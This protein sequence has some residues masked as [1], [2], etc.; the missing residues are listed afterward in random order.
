MKVFKTIIICLFAM[1]GFS[2]SID[3]LFSKHKLV[4]GLTV[5]IKNDSSTFGGFPSNLVAIITFKSDSASVYYFAFAYQQSDSIN[6]SK[7]ELDYWMVSGC[8]I[9]PHKSFDKNFYSFI[10]GGYF[11][12]LQH[13]ACR[14]G[15]NEYCAELASRINQWRKKY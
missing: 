4:A 5:Q 9:V 8:N 14:T 6:F 13:C 7:A 11:F 12:L 15:E 10:Y 3:S 1:Q 2:Q